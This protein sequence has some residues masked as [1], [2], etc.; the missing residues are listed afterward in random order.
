MF[1]Y[2]SLLVKFNHHSSWREQT[3]DATDGV[4]RSIIII[5]NNPSDTSL[6]G[7]GFS[8]Q[9]AVTVFINTKWRKLMMWVENVK[10]VR[11]S[12]MWRELS[13][14]R[15]A[16]TLTFDSQLES[17]ERKAIW[18]QSVG[19]KSVWLFSPPGT[20]TNNKP[21]LELHRHTLA[22]QGSARISSI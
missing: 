10:P 17:K 11:R 12:E 1:R 6:F 22:D 5:H 8:S 16:E 4:S 18:W 15:T 14:L 13:G 21:G 9:K 2:W 20:G 3:A 7:A 19:E